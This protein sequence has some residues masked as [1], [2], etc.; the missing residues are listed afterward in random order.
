M[1]FISND[2]YRLSFRALMSMLLLRA[3]FW[4]QLKT[5]TISNTLLES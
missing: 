5:F 4:V 1:V 2:Y 3:L